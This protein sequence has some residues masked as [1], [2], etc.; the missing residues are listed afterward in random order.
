MTWNM[1]WRDGYVESSERYA[2]D[3]YGRM[4]LISRL[5]DLLSRR[6]SIDPIE[7]RITKEP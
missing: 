4:D 7:I 2:E 6:E 3:V 1:K 5:N